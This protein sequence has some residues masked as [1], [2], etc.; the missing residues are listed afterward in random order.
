V[1][2]RLFTVLSALIRAKSV[3][4]QAVA[5]SAIMGDCDFSEIFCAVFGLDATAPFDGPNLAFST[6]AHEILRQ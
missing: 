5:K 4:E 6:G 1:K 3:E 2:S